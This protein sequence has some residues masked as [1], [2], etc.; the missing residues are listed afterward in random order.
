MIE[1]NIQEQRW[2]K[3]LYYARQFIEREG[4]LRLPDGHE[5]DGYKLASW[6]S[7]QRQAYKSGI[8]AEERRQALEA[9]DGWVWAPKEAAWPKGLCYAQRFVEREGHAR[10]P[11]EHIEGGFKL[12]SWV[13]WQRRYRK[14]DN[15]SAERREAVEALEG[16][17]WD[18][19]DTA[20][21]EGLDY[22]KRF[23]EREAHA[24][25]PLRHVEDGF[26][27]GQWVTRQRKSRKKENLS[28][29]RREALEA[30]EGWTWDAHEAAW[31][32]GLDHAKRF[33]EREGHTRVPLR[34]VKDGFRLGQW[35]KVQRAD[36]KRDELSPERRAALEALDGWVWTRRGPAS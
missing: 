28:A 2:Q 21:Q 24:H 10:V 16:W 35:V 31:Q 6:I 27:L 18:A 13:E 23:V 8:L 30:L 3:G 9:L 7:Y 36:Y 33:V 19:H 34:H 22:S 12:G 1:D 32:K 15:L 26:E 11:T 29:E 5:E 25:V 17:T 4:H 14:R 20:W